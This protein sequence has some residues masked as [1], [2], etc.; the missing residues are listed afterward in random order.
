[1]GIFDGDIPCQ[2]GFLFEAFRALEK[3]Y[4][5]ARAGDNVVGI[6]L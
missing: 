6:E 3:A 1:M 5:Y 2:N 4:N